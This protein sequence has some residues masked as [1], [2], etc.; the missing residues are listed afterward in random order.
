ML[1]ETEEAPNEY[2]AQ[3]PQ[4]DRDHAW[5]SLDNVGADFRLREKLVKQYAWGIPTAEAIQVLVKHSPVIEIAAGLGY[6]AYLADKAGCDIVAF[7]K[8]VDPAENVY[9]AKDAKMWFP[10]AQGSFEK[11]ALHPFRALFLCW[12]PYDESLAFDALQAYEGDRLIYVGETGSGCNADD[13]F[14]KLIDEE[15]Y[16]DDEFVDLPQWNGLHD[17]LII[18]KRQKS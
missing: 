10:V 14:W 11:A 3:I 6:W 4:V 8:F 16:S 15:W 9:A 18:F 5:S 2:L 1:H 7:D 13:A 17:M 12:P